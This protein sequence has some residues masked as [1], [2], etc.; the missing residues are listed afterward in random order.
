M[1]EQMMPGGMGGGGEEMAEG[2]GL[3]VTIDKLPDGTFTV[4][5]NPG[6]PQPAAD[7]DAALEAARTILTAGATPDEAGLEAG[8]A[9]GAAPPRLGRPTPGA[10]FGEGM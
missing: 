9:K 4:S 8:Y 5:Q 7:I 1:P 10:V 3:S 6:E 2:E